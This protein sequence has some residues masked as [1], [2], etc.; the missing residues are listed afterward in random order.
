MSDEERT[1][2]HP[3]FDTEKVSDYLLFPAVFFNLASIFLLFVHPGPANQLSEADF[4][5]A[6]VLFAL[7]WLFSMFVFMQLR[8][9]LNRHAKL[10][11]CK[12]VLGVICALSVWGYRSGL[13]LGDDVVFDSSAEARHRA[14]VSFVLVNIIFQLVFGTA[15]LLVKPPR[16][17]VKL[18]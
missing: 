2:E 11:M 6:A 15:I 13:Q 3:V 12:Q 4:E 18:E 14:A 10:Q 1:A 5:A 8:L 9:V 7:S 16:A 17:F